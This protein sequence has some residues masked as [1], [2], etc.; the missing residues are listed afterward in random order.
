M[1]VKATAQI[2]EQGHVV[3]GPGDLGEFLGR[4]TLGDGT[5]AITARFWGCV[6]T[7]YDGADAEL[8]PFEFTGTCDRCGE[9]SAGGPV[10]EA[11]RAA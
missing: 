8:V 2:V 6:T 1:Q 5:V 7:V 10:H 4:E 3:A 9:L 11:C